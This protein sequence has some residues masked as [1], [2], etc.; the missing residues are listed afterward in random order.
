MLYLVFDTETTG[1]PDDHNAPATDTDKWPRVV[2]LAWAHVSTHSN[3]IERVHS[4]IIQ[5]DGFKIP[6]DA[7]KIHGISTTSASHDGHPLEEVLE[8]FL[9][10]V[11]M[12]NALVAHNINFDLPVMQA[13]LYRQANFYPLI[14]KPTICTK[15]ESTDYCKLPTTSRWHSGY[16]WPSLRE[17][18]ETL[19][20][21][22]FD[23]AHDAGGDVKAGARCFLG[24][25]NR[26]VIDP[27]ADNATDPQSQGS[28]GFPDVDSGFPF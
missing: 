22:D 27:D 25:V 1:T 19:F 24:L 7:W 20:E 6:S 10:A 9:S 21:R 8:A 15:E 17:L 26:G 11:R 4:Y 2:Q 12:S 13:E 28:L 16:K 5:P 14:N 23:N 3:S 18:H